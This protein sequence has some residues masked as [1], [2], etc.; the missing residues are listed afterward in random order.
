MAWHSRCSKS[1]SYFH[2]HE[3]YENI[4]HGK[5][6]PG[7]KSYLLHILVERHFTHSVNSLSFRFPWQGPTAICPPLQESIYHIDYNDSIAY[8]FLSLESLRVWPC[9]NCVCIQDVHIRMGNHA[10]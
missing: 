6:R 2:D 9:G 3:E 4:G 10:C 1:G 5:D 7:L 8:F